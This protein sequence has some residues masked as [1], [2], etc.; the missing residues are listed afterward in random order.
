M[1]RCKPFGEH[2]KLLEPRR[3]FFAAEGIQVSSEKELDEALANHTYVMHAMPTDQTKLIKASRKMPKDQDL[4]DGVHWALMD[5][6]AGVAGINTEVHCPQMIHTLREAK[7]KTKCIM[8]GGGELPVEKVPET[9]V[10]S[11]GHAVYAKSSY[12][13]V[14]CPM[15]SVR[16]IVKQGNTVAASN[17]G[18]YILNKQNERHINVIERE[19]VYFVCMKV[20]GPDE[21]KVDLEGNQAGDYPMLGFVRPEA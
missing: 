8:P 17:G 18:G 14:Q 21:L 15:L 10:E 13:P 11:D 9:D 6:G 1:I 16:Q 4:A 12:L 2:H 20:P 5:S 7:K 19:S 3:M